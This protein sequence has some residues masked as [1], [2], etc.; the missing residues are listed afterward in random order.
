[1]RKAKKR[2]ITVK[3]STKK[4][5]AIEK[6]KVRGGKTLNPTTATNGKVFMRKERLLTEKKETAEEKPRTSR[7]P[8][9]ERKE[10]VPRRVGADDHPKGGNRVANK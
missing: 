8:E 1:V 6:K 2:V 5:E 3:R 4:N 10:R 9:G 7:G